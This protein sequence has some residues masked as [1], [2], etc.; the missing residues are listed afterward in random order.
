[1][2]WTLLRRAGAL[3]KAGVR[4]ALQSPLFQRHRPAWRNAG[5]PACSLLGPGKHGLMF[6]TSAVRKSRLE[7]GLA[8]GQ[9]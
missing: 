1:M 9:E 2:G 3:A 7:S 6:D 4:A 8:D 5:F